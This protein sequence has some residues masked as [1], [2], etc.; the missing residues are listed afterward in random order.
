MRLRPE[1]KRERPGRYRSVGD[2]DEEY[3]AIMGSA[4][5]ARLEFGSGRKAD[6][7]F[8]APVLVRSD[9]SL[10]TSPTPLP[11]LHIHIESESQ[12]VLLLAVH[13]SFHMA[14]T[15][16]WGTRRPHNR[17]QQSHENEGTTASRSSIR[18][19]R[20]QIDNPVAQIHTGAKPAAFPS[21]PTDQAAP[22]DMQEKGRHGLW[23]CTKALR[24][25]EE[26]S[27][28]ALHNVHLRV[29]LIYKNKQ[30]PSTMKQREKAWYV[31]LNDCWLPNEA[32]T[33]V[34]RI[35]CVHVVAVQRVFT[36]IVDFHH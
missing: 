18:A 2:D 34:R 5:M 10:F 32:P 14:R 25:D 1:S 31:E 7:V 26:G 23:Q 3:G 30:F 24:A 27:R 8:F 9:S 17:N 6:I 28:A 21:L 29:D 33:K 11:Q 13:N 19:A 36:S 16:N 22:E 12:L 35:V 4:S 20:Q 15:E